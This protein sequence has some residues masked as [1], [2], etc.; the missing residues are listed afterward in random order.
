MTNVNDIGGQK[1][2]SIIFEIKIDPKRCGFSRHISIVSAA[3]TVGKVLLRVR[4]SLSH[5]GPR[6]LNIK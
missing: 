5:V 6:A 4:E 1:D 3:C 2:K